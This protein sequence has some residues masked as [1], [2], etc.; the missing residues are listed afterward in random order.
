MVERRFGRHLHQIRVAVRG[1]ALVEVVYPASAYA[2]LS[3]TP[4]TPVQMALRKESIVVIAPRHDDRLAEPEP[5]A[6]CC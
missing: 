4:G 6:A 2:T 1:G 3:L 5:A